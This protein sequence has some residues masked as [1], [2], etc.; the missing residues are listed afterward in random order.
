MRFLLNKRTARSFEQILTDLASLVKLDS[1]VVKKIFALSG[2]PITKLLD[3]FS[4]DKIFL[5]CGS[6]KITV[7]DFYLD[8]EGLV[9]RC[10][11]LP[12]IVKLDFQST[13]SYS[14]RDPVAIAYR[15][16]HHRQRL[17]TVESPL[18]TH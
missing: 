12:S 6:E 2:R 18:A 9:V 14:L 1:G 10:L 13:N 11:L 17:P 4:D 3:F 5:V 8:S 7:D 16:M 15:T